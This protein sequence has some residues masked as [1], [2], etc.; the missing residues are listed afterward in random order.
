M[1]GRAAPNKGVPMSEEQ[2]NKM[3]KIWKII[4]PLNEIMMIKN[5]GEFCRKSNLTTAN[6]LKVAA[7]QRSHHKKYKC[8]REEDA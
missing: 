1:K 4:T 3:S 2:K 5:L 6:M 7:G 8:F